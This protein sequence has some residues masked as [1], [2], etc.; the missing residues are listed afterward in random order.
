MFPITLVLQALHQ[1]RRPSLAPLQHLNVSLA[2]RG[3]ELNTGFQVRPHQCPV[4]GH[5]PCP[6]PAATLVLLQAR[7]LLASWLPGHSCSCSA[8]SISTPSSFPMSSFQPLFPKPGALQGVVVVQVQDF[9]FLNLMPLA[10]AHGSSLSTS[11]CRTS[12][13]PA[14]Q[15]SHPTWCHLQI[16]PCQY[17]A[18]RSSLHQ[19][20]T[21]EATMAPDT[22][23]VSIAQCSQSLPQALLLIPHPKYLLVIF[24]WFT[25]NQE[26]PQSGASPP[27]P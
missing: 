22:A 25:P 16:Y 7:M 20:R 27:V 21:I 17:G 3:P 9:A 8:P 13:P 24:G 4:Q 18:V 11:L 5:N 26:P 15:H 10:T 19:Y 12:Y 14:D 23:G 1:L 6:G 2:V